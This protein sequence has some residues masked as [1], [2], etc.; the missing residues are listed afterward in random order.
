MKVKCGNLSLI[1]AQVCPC[2]CCVRAYVYVWRRRP[3]WGCSNGRNCWRIRGKIG[4]HSG[5]SEVNRVVW[6]SLS[7]IVLPFYWAL[8]AYNT[9][10]ISKDGLLQ[11]FKAVLINWWS[12]WGNRNKCWRDEQPKILIYQYSIGLHPPTSPAG[13]PLVKWFHSFSWSLALLW[14]A[15]EAGKLKATV[16]ENK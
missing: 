8:Q 13:K 6:G 14:W 5:S 9:N 2:T 11:S 7:A 10:L 3:R 12:W 15:G 4:A 16:V 1:N